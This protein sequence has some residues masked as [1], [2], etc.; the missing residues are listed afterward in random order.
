MIHINKKSPINTNPLIFEFEIDDDIPVEYIQCES[1]YATIKE[2]SRNCFNNNKL[3]QNKIQSLLES[4]SNENLYKII[5]DVYEFNENIMGKTWPL[6]TNKYKNMYE[7]VKN[8][9]LVTTQIFMDTPGF[10]LG[11]HFDNRFVFSN[12]ILNLVDNP[13]STKFYD[14]T[15]NYKLIYEAP[16]E[17]GKGIFF[18][19]Y[20]NSCHSYINDSFKNRYCIIS[21]IVLKM[22]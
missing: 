2:H 13:V 20:E 6:A 3:E 18:I 1:N 19:N 10:S 21:S 5:N 14:Y 4:F 8:N 17:K 22:F 11:P 7:F 9:T 16:K 15:Q 12:F